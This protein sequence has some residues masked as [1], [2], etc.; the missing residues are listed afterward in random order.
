MNKDLCKGNNEG[1]K[2][3]FTSVMLLMCKI[4]KTCEMFLRR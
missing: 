3:V 1:A 4:R 2:N